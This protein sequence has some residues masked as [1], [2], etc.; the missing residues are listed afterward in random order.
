MAGGTQKTAGGWH[1][2]GLRVL[3][4]AGPG[5]D[6]DPGEGRAA[7]KAGGRR[8]SAIKGWLRTRLPSRRVMLKWTLVLKRI[9][10]AG[11][12][13]YGSGVHGCLVVTFLLTKIPRSYSEKSQAVSLS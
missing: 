13:R 11:K 1:Y 6:V 4:G 12:D 8:S 3:A 2:C 5:I 10:G 7:G 9:C